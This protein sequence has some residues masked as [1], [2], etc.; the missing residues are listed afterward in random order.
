MPDFKKNT[1]FS[2]GPRKSFDR[3]GS[4]P[5]FKG[6]RDFGGPKQM[7]DAECSNCHKMCQVPFRPNGTKPVFCRD[8]FNPEES[9]RSSGDR[10]ERKSFAP[11]RSSAPR[12]QEDRRID[13]LKRQMDTMNA[14]LERI[15]GLLEKSNRAADLSSELEKYKEK[16]AKKVAPKKVAK[17]ATKKTK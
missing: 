13:D 9:P 10:F 17:K 12:P 8:C 15:A 11:S 6:G 5:P 7:F 3:G 1:R 14:T 4:R 2:G 16:P